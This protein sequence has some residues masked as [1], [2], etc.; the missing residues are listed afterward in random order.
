MK[1]AAHPN[2]IRCQTTRALIHHSA[3]CDSDDEIMGKKDGPLSVQDP[4]DTSA[5]MNSQ[6]TYRSSQNQSKSTSATTNHYTANE[7]SSAAGTPSKDAVAQDQVQVNGTGGIAN[8][9]TISLKNLP[10]EE[11]IVKVRQIV[12]ELEK[13]EEYHRGE[14]MRYQKMLGDFYWDYADHRTEIA[15]ALSDCGYA[16]LTVKMLKTMNTMGIFKNDDIWFPTY[17]TYNTAW[18]YSD[19]SES[20]AKNLAEADA[21][22]LLT[23]NLGHKPY[24][25]NIQSKNVYYVLKASLSTLHNI[26]RCSDVKHFF[27]ENKTAEVIM[28]FISMK[29]EFLKAISMLTLAYIVEEEENTKLIDETNTISSIVSWT[30]N[31]VDGGSKRRFKGF[32]P[33]ELTQGLDK[34]AVNDTNKIQV[35]EAGALPVFLRMLQHDDPKEQSSTAHCIWTLS[36]DKTV[37]QKIIEHEGLVA[38]LENLSKNENSE[39]RKNCLGALW[40]IKGENDP[41]TTTRP[42]SAL[43]SKSHIFISYSWTEKELVKE[44]RERLRAENYKVWIDYEQMGGS[45]LQAMAEA[46]ENAAVVLLC[47]SEKYKQSPNCR[48]EAEY[49]FQQRKEYIPLMMQKKYRPDGWLG[50]ILGAKLFFDFSGKYPFEK[51]MQGLLKELR[52]RGQLSHMTDST[53]EVDGLIAAE[54]HMLIEGNPHKTTVA[55]HMALSMSRD[56]VTQWLL[57]RHLDICVPHMAQ[58]DGKLLWQLK[59]MKD[60]APQFFF[61]LLDTKLK[62]SFVDILRFTA[63]I[64]ELH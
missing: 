12:A 30:E 37:R 17:Y 47:M 27:K 3:V 15:N 4:R 49:T 10:I 20:L 53:D 25:S 38:A 34:L 32:T 22:R 35:V 42:K 43:K 36:F 28:P 6:E 64:D 61:H 8:E 9:T 39:V 11:V 59:L 58:L 26:A 18:N 55:A 57:N 13:L 23:L 24:L 31:A 50:A 21:V 44:I 51:S 7:A 46:V 60:E 29:D 2:V 63:A 16:A 1:S 54:N 45:T 40:M 56:D 19:A 14:G 52:G 48:T 41:A 5:M 62:L 33:W